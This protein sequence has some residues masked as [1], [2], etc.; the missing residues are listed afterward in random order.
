MG[1]YKSYMECKLYKMKGDHKSCSNCDYTDCPKYPALDEEWLTIY[2]AIEKM[3]LE[4]K[5]M[6]NAA[7]MKHMY[8]Y[9]DEKTQEIVICMENN[10]ECSFSECDFVEIFSDFP[11][12]WIVTGAYHGI[13]DGMKKLI[14]KKTER[15]TPDQQKKHENDPVNYPSHY[16]DGKIEVIEYIEDKKLGFCL[17]NAVKYI[18][19]AGKKDPEKEIEDLEKAEWYIKRRIEE[20]KK[21]KGEKNK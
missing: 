2:E 11:D 18:S 4:N 21:E 5:K 15:M 19:R 9:Y 17:G 12:C 1:I 3:K 16:T 13:F 7:W 14:R 10:N 8:V 6:T 20:L